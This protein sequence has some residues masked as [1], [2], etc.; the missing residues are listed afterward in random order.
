MSRAI[1]GLDVRLVAA[2]QNNSDLRCV[3][4]CNTYY[5]VPYDKHDRK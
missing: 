1:V 4:V 5:I 3:Y 2:A